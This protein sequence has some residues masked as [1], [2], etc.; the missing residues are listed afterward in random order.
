MLSKSI[1]RFWTDIKQ[2]GVYMWTD[3][4]RTVSYEGIHYNQSDQEV[5]LEIINKIIYNNE[6]LF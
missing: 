1:G 2:F 3:L 6:K 4:E 5:L